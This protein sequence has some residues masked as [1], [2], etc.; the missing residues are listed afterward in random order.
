[1]RLSRRFRLA[2]ENSSLEVI[3]EGF[4]LANRSNFRTVNNTVGAVPLSAL[5]ARIEA[6]KGPSPT[7]PLAFTSAH[8]ARQFQFAMK[9]FW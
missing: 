6:V 5:P 1:M 3:A 4:N 8:D 2:S 9:I 7:T